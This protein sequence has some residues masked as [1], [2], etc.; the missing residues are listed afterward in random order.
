MKSSRVIL[1]LAFTLTV[2]RTA[3]IPSAALP[4]HDD[5]TDGWGLLALFTNI[6]DQVTSSLVPSAVLS[7]T[8][9]ASPEPSTPPLSIGVTASPEASQWP[10]TTYSAPKTYTYYSAPKLSAQPATTATI[11]LYAVH[12]APSTHQP[13]GDSAS[14]HDESSPARPVSAEDLFASPEPSESPESAHDATIDIAECHSDSVIYPT[15]GTVF[16]A[17]ACHLL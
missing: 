15:H 3:P 7:P 4:V 9:Y 11:Q 2:A 17:V 6:L 16:A 13:H 10:R 5:D 12:N 14:S 1:F 8:Q